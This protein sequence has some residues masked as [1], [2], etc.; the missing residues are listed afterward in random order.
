MEKLL[1]KTGFFPI[2]IIA[3]FVVNCQQTKSI[4]EKIEPAHTE[5]IEDSELIKLTLTDRAVERLGIM[6]DTI[7][8]E[9]LI[10]DNGEQSIQ[11]V[12]PYASIIYDFN[13]QTWVYANPEQNVYIRH[14]IKVNFIKGQKVYLLEG[15]PVGTTVVIQG[16]AELYGTE[17]DVGH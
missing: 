12:T 2:I 3:L 4:Y 14:E 7:T 9:S 6:T 10:D 15:P 13:G 11:K 17:Y 1:Y 16:A 5:H 8:E